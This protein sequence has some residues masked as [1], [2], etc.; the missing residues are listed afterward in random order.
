MFSGRSLQSAT[1]L[2][3]YECQRVG[4]TS[5]LNFVFALAPLDF[6]APGGDVYGGSLPS[7]E[8][9]LVY[10]CQRVGRANGANFV[11]S[12]FRC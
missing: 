2:L 5:G 10:S 11:F 1:A 3:V 8:T 9:L 12:P 7:A 4:R 6:P